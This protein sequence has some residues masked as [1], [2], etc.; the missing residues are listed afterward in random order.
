[1]TSLAH[2]WL[3]RCDPTS[4]RFEAELGPDAT[5]HDDDGTTTLAAGRAT[6]PSKAEWSPSTRTLRL[7]RDRTGRHPLF[8]ARVGPTLVASTD[9]RALLRE[10][11]VSRAPSAVV[12]AEWLLERNGRPE[13]TL[14]DAV[15]RVPA[16]HVLTLADGQ[17][18]NVHRE[19]KPPET[20][21]F[22]GEASARFGATLEEAVGGVLD[23]PAAVFLSGGIDS[24][25][26]AA[27]AATVS[28]ARGLPPPLALCA[29]IE[30]SSEATTQRA[31]ADALGLELVERSFGP[32]PGRL[33]EALEI[34]GTSLWP[35]DSAWAVVFEQLLTDARRGGADGAARRRRRRRAPRRWPR[36]RPRLPP[37]RAAGSVA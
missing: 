3:L 12:V 25:A 10:P 28:S 19:W 21:T 37:P 2:G 14:I 34:T 20:G 22:P 6:A 26:V 1:M 24:A 27:A 5:R 9:L 23:G 13:E 32:A 16:G 36:L 4:G 18:E 11:G 8:Y 15:R 29:D 35:V 30:G 17:P 7:V 33:Q 31:V